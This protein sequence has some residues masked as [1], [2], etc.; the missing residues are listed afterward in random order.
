MRNLPGAFPC[1][2][3]TCVCEECVLMNDVVPAN[4]VLLITHAFPRAVWVCAAFYVRFNL[5]PNDQCAMVGNYSFLLK[6][7]CFTS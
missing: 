2:A 6:V 4:S 1:K 3:A 5:D 7:L